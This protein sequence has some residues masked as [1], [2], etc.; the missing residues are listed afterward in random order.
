VEPKAKV[1]WFESKAVDYLADLTVSNR[2]EDQRIRSSNFLLMFDWPI[3]T[4]W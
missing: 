2:S 4:P 3:E 1:R